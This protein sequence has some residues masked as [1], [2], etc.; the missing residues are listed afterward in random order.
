M[1]TEQTARI[2]D[3]L[4]TVSAPLDD[5]SVVDSYPWPDSTW[6]RALMVLNL[7]GDVAGPDGSSR[8]IS[9]PADRQVL[10]ACRRF[11][12]AVVIGA[13]TMRAEV[14]SPMRMSGER[15]E[16]RRADGLAP[17]PRLVIV[18]ASLD[19]PW[20]ADAFHTSTLS[21]LILASAAAPA[22][23]QASVPAT[24]ELVVAPGPIL[25]P[26][27]IISALTERGLHRILLEGGPHVLRQMAAAGCVDE[28]ALTVS[29]IV[30]EQHFRPVLARPQ[31]EFVF[32]RFVRDGKESS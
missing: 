30:G 25:D 9:G 17:A 15:Q 8:S 27:W 10:A 19:L 14:Y 23:R 26:T 2:D 28:W 6:V 7:D 3:R 21:P 18:T 11:A 16:A 22:D 1:G 31:E 5:A 13:Q 32:T 29:G 4:S 12:D 20:S 24:C